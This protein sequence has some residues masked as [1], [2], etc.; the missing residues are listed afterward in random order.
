MKREYLVMGAGHQGLAMS[1]HLALNDECVNLWNRTPENIIELAN[2]PEIICKGCISGRARLNKV[3]HNIDDVICDVILIA[4][5][6]TAYRDIAKIL[7]PRILPHTVVFLNPGRTFGAI[8][9]YNEL[10]KNGCTIMPQIAETQSI[11]YT[12][13]RVSVKEVCIYTLKRD[14][15]IAPLKNDG[16]DILSKL[17][18]CLQDK[19]ILVNSILETS[20]G[21]VGMILHCAPVLLNIGW[22]ESD[23]HEFR[24]YYDGIS[25][26]VAALLQKLDDERL[27]IARRMGI[28]VDSLVQWLRKSYGIEGD[29]IL[30]CIHNNECYS[31]IDAPI[32]LDHRYLDEDVPNGLV[33]LEFLAQSMNIEVPVTK[34]VIDLACVVKECDYRASGRRISIETIM[35]ITG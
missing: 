23:K 6:S 18:E 29:T 20:L 11:V 27:A 14:I 21:N 1:A 34:L 32:S 31:S 24:Y 3:S 30:E 13:R 33:P 8:E 26:S 2:E 16:D 7:A 19:F 28:K 17:P 35:K 15:K 5:P 10:V 4:A 22:I 12:C 9:F 25:K